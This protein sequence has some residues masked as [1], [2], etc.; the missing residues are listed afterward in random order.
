MFYNHVLYMYRDRKKWLTESFVM[1]NCDS[2]CNLHLCT[3]I[4]AKHS[5]KLQATWH[6]NNCIA[7]RTYVFSLADVHSIP[8]Q[9]LL[10]ISR[11][12]LLEV[13]VY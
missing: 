6:W 3:S 8:R 13:F 7:I 5:L 9:Y 1:C 10:N 12:S 2:L 11:R 4:A